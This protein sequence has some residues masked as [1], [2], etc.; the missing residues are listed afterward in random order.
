[1]SD[2]T[3]K[4]NRAGTLKACYCDQVRIGYVENTGDDRWVWTLNMLQPEGGRATGIVVSEAKAKAA[5]T[6]ALVLWVD[7]AGLEFKTGGAYYN[8]ND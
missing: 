5:L 6:D 3:Y 4:S 1:M 2:L 7:A 8:V